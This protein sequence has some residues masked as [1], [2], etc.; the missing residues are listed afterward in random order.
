VEANQGILF[1]EMGRSGGDFGKEAGA[2][3]ALFTLEAVHA[4]AARAKPAVLDQAKSALNFFREKVIPVS[5]QV[6][7]LKIFWLHLTESR[8]YH[9]DDRF[10]A[11]CHGE[12]IV[13]G[14]QGGMPSWSQGVGSCPAREGEAAS[15]SERWKGE[16]SSPS[17][18]T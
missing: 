16:V 7:S 17:K 14:I 5:L 9:I 8:L 10:A 11:A 4:T 13:G 3:K 2:A 1:S 12:P 6:S 15:G 18:L